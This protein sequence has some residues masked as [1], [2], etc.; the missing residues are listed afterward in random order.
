M[1]ANDVI[2]TMHAAMTV[3]ARS[4]LN[5]V[6]HNT[7]P[8]VIDGRD[9]AAMQLFKDAWAEEEPF[10]ARLVVMIEEL[11]G[12][13]TPEAAFRFAP[14]RL[15]FSVAHHLLGV[16]PPLIQ[17]EIDVLGQF[18]EE[19][20]GAAPLGKLLRELIAV[21]TRWMDAMVE[22]HE[23][24]EEAKRQERES[25][26]QAAAASGAGAGSDDPMS[27]RDADMELEDRMARVE[28]QPLDMKLWAA[29]AQ[30]DCTACGYDCEGYAKALASGEEKDPNKCVPGEEDTANMVKK[31]L[32]NS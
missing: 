21:K 19:V 27:F 29:M 25:G 23:K 32:G 3:E 30:T 8:T 22:A 9:E 10:L 14:S 7:W 5:Y 6:L 15:N 12:D 28:N 18:A 4:V 1:I 11:G 24:N 31:L 16:V 26:A 2:E 17:D 13:P 20:A